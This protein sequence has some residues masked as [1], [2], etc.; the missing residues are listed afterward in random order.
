[1]AERV[2]QENGVKH[3]LPSGQVE[4]SG[5][6]GDAVGGA[7]ESVAPTAN[8]LDKL[9]E[10]VWRGKQ[11]NR[12]EIEQR[13]PRV[14]GTRKDTDDAGGT[15]ADRDLTTLH[16]W[17]FGFGWDSLIETLAALIDAE[18]ERDPKVATGYRTD[19]GWDMPPFHITQMKEKFGGLRFY[20]EGGNIRIHGLAE[21]TEELSKGMCEVCGT[22]GDQCKNGGWVST[23][24]PECADHLGYQPMSNA[25]EDGK[26]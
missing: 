9:K 3:D 15:D 20:Y 22:I 14:F 12:V 2:T 7:M 23:L 13:Y 6:G 5:G 16:E 19:D 4:G 11:R 26:S 10:E 8:P 17:E 1:M 18:I 21:M 25:E 24:C